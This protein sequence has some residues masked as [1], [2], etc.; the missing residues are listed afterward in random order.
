MAGKF[1]S[2]GKTECWYILDADE[3]AEIIYGHTAHSKEEFINLLDS[4]KYEELLIR[5][6]VKKGDFFFIPAGMVHAV[7]KGILILEIQQSSDITYRLY[8]YDRIEKDGKKRELHLD[9]GLEATKFPSL[10]VYNKISS[11][12]DN[13]NQVITLIEYRYFNVYK[14]NLKNQFKIYNDPFSLLTFI[15]GVGSINGYPYKKGDSLIVPSTIKEIEINPVSFTE[16]V[17]AKL[18]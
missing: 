3:G 15:D 17:V 2:Y 16:V 13:D 8:D 12:V 11:V 18:P 9:L 7:G 6:P 5:Q 1:N 10:T 4:G 14:W